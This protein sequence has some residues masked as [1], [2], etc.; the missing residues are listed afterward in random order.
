MIEYSC[1]TEIE[2]IG[3]NNRYNLCDGHAMHE[4]TI[5]QQKIISDLTSLWNESEKK[6]VFE[7]QVEYLDAF[8]SLAQDGELRASRNFCI[9]T[10]ASQS[11]DMFAAYCF[12]KKLKVALIEP[13]FDNLGQ[14][15]RRWGIEPVSIN[16]D[17]IFESDCDK[18]Y[19]LSSHFDVLF[20]VNPNNPSGKNMT[21]K[22][23]DIVISFCVNERKILAVDRC[24]RLFYESS[25]YL[26]KTVLDAKV[27]FVFIEDTGKVWPTQEI[28]A[29]ILICSDNLFAEIK[30]IYREINLA[31]SVFGL[32][33]LSRFIK[34][35]EKIGLDK[36]IWLPVAERRAYLRSIL[37]GTQLQFPRFALTSKLPVEWLLFS[38]SSEEAEDL[39]VHMI[40][41]ELT[42]L[43]GKY[44]YWK[45]LQA[46]HN[47]FRVALMKKL[48]V[49][50]Y[51]VE[52]I[53][54]S[55]ETFSYDC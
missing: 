3:L 7:S 53:R 51:G 33:L 26:T 27:S 14:I 40:K 31:V 17:I 24:F 20:L 1:L 22:Q 36:D 32:D 16:E 25:S 41:H 49:F 19:E 45:S 34:H 37:S 50:K 21:N 2:E 5:H 48:S 15:F 12:R 4:L 6:N 54:E 13:T 38:G 18:L 39:Y 10:S 35:S 11:I 8:Y 42:I 55:L 23:V 43:P 47:F 44:F 29:S 52:K 9:C 28:K 46:P 30:Q